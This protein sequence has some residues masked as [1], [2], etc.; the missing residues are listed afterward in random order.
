MATITDNLLDTKQ[1]AD[2]LGLSLQ[3]F[4]LHAAQGTGPAFLQLGPRG[5]KRR[6][7]AVD[8]D[9]WVESR[10]VSAKPT[11]GSLRHIK[12]KA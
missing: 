3:S 9:A 6:F 1:A 12:A 4:R 8:L 5:G 7:L 11:R 10:R 2:Y